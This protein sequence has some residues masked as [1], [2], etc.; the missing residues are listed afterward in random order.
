VAAQHQA[1][2]HQHP[3]SANSHSNPIAE[4]NFDPFQQQRDCVMH[5]GEASASRSSGS[6]SDASESG[7][8][9]DAESSSSLDWDDFRASA[10]DYALEDGGVLLRSAEDIRSNRGLCALTLTQP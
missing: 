10:V 2:Q 3:G 6:D 4:P 5:S 8:S 7:A 9:S 1:T